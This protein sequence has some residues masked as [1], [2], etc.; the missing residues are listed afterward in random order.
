MPKPQ[1]N[2]NGKLQYKENGRVDTSSNPIVSHDLL[3][4][5][6]WMENNQGELISQFSLDQ[7][8]DGLKNSD[9]VRNVPFL[10]MQVDAI[11]KAGLAFY[12]SNGLADRYE[13]LSPKFK[14]IFGLSDEEAQNLRISSF[15]QTYF[16]PKDFMVMLGIIKEACMRAKPNGSES[17]HL[18]S[19]FNIRNNQTVWLEQWQTIYFDDKCRPALA[20][21][22]LQDVTKMKK[23]E[24]DRDRALGCIAHDLRNPVTIIKGY[25][26]VIEMQTSHLLTPQQLK[27]IERSISACER[28]TEMTNNF[29]TLEKVNQVFKN[30]NMELVDVYDF[31]QSQV[32]DLELLINGKDLVFNVDCQQSIGE[33]MMNKKMIDQVLENL[34]TN[35][36]KYS[37]RGGT[38]NLSVY[39]NKNGNVEFRIEDHGVGMTDD[40]CDLLFQE[41]A[42]IG[43]NPTNGELSTGLGLTICKRIIDHHHGRIWCDSIQ[44]KGSTFYFTLPSSNNN[45]PTNGTSG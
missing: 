19:R 32:S 11:E 43:S 37:F 7:L 16:H 25:L 41:Y 22:C 4:Q 42:A 28:M 29:L 2:G 35:A 6:R 24:E 45:Q 34:I 8:A 44:D 5:I 21:A 15:A 23:A 36:A 12:I 10:Q 33:V 14:E 13:Y 40:D 18:I 38:I 39:R 27:M 26:S 1:S 31:I 30:E 20:I 17:V 9:S 3:D